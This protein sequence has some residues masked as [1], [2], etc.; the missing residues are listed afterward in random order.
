MRAAAG[1]RQKAKWDSGR[2]YS[3][4]PAFNILCRR[5]VCW[6]PCEPPI[7]DRA[8]NIVEALLVL[9]R[10]RVIGVYGERLG[11]GGKGAVEIGLVFAGFIANVPA[12]R[13]DRL[14]ADR[15]LRKS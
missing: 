2:L 5:F 1:C 11:V 4:V 10:E 15:R 8:L 3:I 6:K 14:L 13:L 9:L 12:R 7:S